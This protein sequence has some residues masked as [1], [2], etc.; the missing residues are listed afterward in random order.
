MQQ[1]LYSTL[2]VY[3]ATAIANAMYLN[4]KIFFLEKSLQST[5][6]KQNSLDTIWYIHLDLTLLI[7]LF[8]HMHI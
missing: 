7:Y 8:N 1:P 6:T 4:S 3:L 5:N 2:P